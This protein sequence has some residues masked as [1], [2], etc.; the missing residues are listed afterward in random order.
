MELRSLRYFVAVAEELHFGRAAARLHMSQPPLSRAIKRLEAEIGAALFDRSAAGVGLTP[1]GSVLLDEARALLDHAERARVRVA[2]AAGAATLTV[3][4]LGD[5]TDPA[6]TR[7]AAAYRRRHPHVEVRI[8]ETDLT[9]PLC[10]VHA[11]LVDVALTR[12]PFDETGLTV[13]ELRTDPVGALL[14]AD[15][16]LARRDVLELA[17]LADRRWFV[18]PEGTDSRWQLYWNGGQ[19]RE[20]PVVRA[21]QECRQSVL[22]NG[23]VGMTLLSHQ[24]AQGLVVVPVVDMPPSRAVVAWKEGDTDP[25]IR[26][27]VETASAA[28]GSG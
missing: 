27:F 9:D 17:D 13:R 18:F 3:G 22:W 6:A 12:G 21:V 5:S 11:G 23:T 26:S 20:G 16:P 1:V 25:L 14:R 24:P 7:L 2:A 4:F 28:Y 10:G 19:P 15:D 8:R